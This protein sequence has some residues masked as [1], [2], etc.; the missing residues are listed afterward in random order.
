MH[1]LTITKSVISIFYLFFA[2]FLQAG[3][4]TENLIL[5]LEPEA[6]SLYCKY[7]Q[8]EKTQ[9]DGNKTEIV[10]F[11]PGTRYLVLDLGGKIII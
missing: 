4:K 5:A 10:P 2:L 6:A 3:I 7:L 8:T 9:V 11:Q 1:T